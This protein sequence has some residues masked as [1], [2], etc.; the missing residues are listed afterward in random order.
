MGLDT[1]VSVDLERHSPFQAALHSFMDYSN[2]KTPP[3]I[4]VNFVGLLYLHQF[5]VFF[6]DQFLTS[7]KRAR[8]D[9]IEIIDNLGNVS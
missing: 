5:T 8:D 7:V 4:L 3:R 9:C 6:N 1:T 2:E